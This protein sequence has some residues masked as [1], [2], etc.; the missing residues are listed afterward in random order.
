MDKEIILAKPLPGA[1]VGSVHPIND[2]G[3]VGIKNSHKKSCWEDRYL[4]EQLVYIGFAEYVK[5]EPKE[6]ERIYFIDIS[7]EFGLYINSAICHGLNIRMNNLIANNNWRRTEAE[8][9]AVL[10]KWLAI[11]K[12]RK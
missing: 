12:E 11:A 1:E 7:K 3:W 10:D 2:N 9:Q 4:A 8:M 6:G 5:D